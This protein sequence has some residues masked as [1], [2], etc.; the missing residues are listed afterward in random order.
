LIVA[1][2]GSPKTRFKTLVFI[3]ADKQNPPK[4]E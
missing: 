3:N 1:A 4:V 2:C